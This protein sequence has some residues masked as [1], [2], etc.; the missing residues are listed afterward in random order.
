MNELPLEVTNKG[1]F[2]QALWPFYT[3]SPYLSHVLVKP[4]PPKKKKNNLKTKQTN[5]ETAAK[6]HWNLLNCRGPE[7]NSRWWQEMHLCE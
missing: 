6:I 3:V 7:Q 2:I 5:K 4:N 1:G